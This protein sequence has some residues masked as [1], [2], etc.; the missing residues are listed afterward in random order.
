MKKNISFKKKAALPYDFIKQYK[1]T[2]D[3]ETQMNI[4]IKI[5]KKFVDFFKKNYTET[6]YLN[7]NEFNILIIK[8]KLSE[9]ITITKEDKKD[10]LASFYKSYTQATDDDQKK[11]LLKLLKEIFKNYFINKES[12]NIKIENIDNNRLKD[13]LEGVTKYSELNYFILE[14]YKT[15]ATVDDGN[16]L[17]DAIWQGLTEHAKDIIKQKIKNDYQEDQPYKNL[18]SLIKHS[19]TNKTYSRKILNSNTD[20]QK[21]ITYQD[22]EDYK[23]LLDQPEK[24]WGR[25][26]IEGLIIANE[27]NIKLQLIGGEEYLA[28]HGYIQRDTYTIFEP[29]NNPEATVV[30]ISNSHMHYEYCTPN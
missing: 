30:R 9:K 18:K 25:H 8:L 13:I 20:E 17:Y 12:T 16:C 27:L 5:R 10:F 7:Q 1:S 28:E 19:L 6:Q 15:H 14:G 22:I 2:T 26:L 4:F 23:T 21:N 11:D 24:L 3:L 29:P